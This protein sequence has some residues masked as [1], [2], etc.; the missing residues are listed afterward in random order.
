L[1][2]TRPA[3][4]ASIRRRSLVNRVERLVAE[5]DRSSGEDD[6]MLTVDRRQVIEARPPLL[7]L[8]EIMRGDEPVSSTGLAMVKRLLTDGCSPIFSAAW[9]G[10]EAEPGALERDAQAAL[11]ALRGRDAD[12]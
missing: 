10:S 6:V 3:L 2:A 4:G 7:E 8:I 1:L 9:R 11:A 5:A 12:L